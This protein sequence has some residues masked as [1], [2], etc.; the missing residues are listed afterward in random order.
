MFEQT[1]RWMVSWDLFTPEQAENA[2][3]AEA[4]LA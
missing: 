1:H 3:Y 2:R 4:V